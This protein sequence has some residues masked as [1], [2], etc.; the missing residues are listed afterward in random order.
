VADIKTK[1]RV[2]YWYCMGCIQV[3]DNTLLNKAV[4][5]VAPRNLRTSLPFQKY[6]MNSHSSYDSTQAKRNNFLK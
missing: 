1:L 4:K 6:F 5:R 3:D 2:L